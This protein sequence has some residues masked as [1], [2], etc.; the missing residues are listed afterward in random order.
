MF[1]SGDSNRYTDDK[2]FIP[3]MFGLDGVVDGMVRIV[4]KPSFHPEEVWDISRL[5]AMTVYRALESIWYSIPQLVMIGGSKKW[6]Y[7]SEANFTPDKIQKYD[8]GVIGLNSDIIKSV[9]E[10]EKPSLAC[11]DGIGFVLSFIHNG[12]VVHFSV[13]PPRKDTVLHEHLIAIFTKL[14]SLGCRSESQKYMGLA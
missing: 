12:K 13:H 11:V 6:E 3:M 5:G 2:E 8:L 9:M 7:A 1:T 10:Y 4:V 14:D